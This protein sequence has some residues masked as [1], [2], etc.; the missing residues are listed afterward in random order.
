MFASVV[1]SASRAG[2]VVVCV[3]AAIFVIAAAVS[4][5]H[6]YRAAG[7]IFASLLVCTLVAGWTSV[8]ER[9][10][11]PDLFAVRRELFAATVEMIR[12]KPLTGFGLGAWPS[13]Y[14]AFATI[15][16]PGVFMNHA[17]NDW[18]EWTAEGGL[19]FVTLLM[20]F[21]CAMT[22]RLRENLWA[23]GIPAVLAHAFVDFPLQK[24]ALACAVFWMAGVAVA[25]ALRSASRLAKAA[26]EPGSCERLP[27]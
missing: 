12:A 25:S 4:R 26:V 17:H 20:V 19:P 27:L 15:D 18:A 11:I 3:E 1:A 9:F 24:P 14:P 13:V 23:L 8:W 5:R 2:T 21:A 7:L 6:N 22:M 10:L 16:P